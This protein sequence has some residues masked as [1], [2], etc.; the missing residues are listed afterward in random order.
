MLEDT[1][2][3]RAIQE[4]KDSNNW[5]AQLAAQHFE[6]TGEITVKRVSKSENIGI[7]GSSKDYFSFN[8]PNI[9]LK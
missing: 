3:A 2:M 4:G 6:K 8:C 5:P 9:P 7:S 1:A